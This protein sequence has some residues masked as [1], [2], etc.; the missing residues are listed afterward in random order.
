MALEAATLPIDAVVYQ[1]DLEG[2]AIVLARRP[3]TLFDVWLPEGD[4]EELEIPEPP[5]L[6]L[7]GWADRGS[8][9]VHAGDELE[10]SVEWSGD[11]VRLT[12]AQVQ[13]LAA[14]ES[15]WEHAPHEDPLVVER[16][17]QLA[18]IDRLG[19]SLLGF[20]VDRAQLRTQLAE[21]KGALEAAP[22]EFA[23]SLGDAL[24]LEEWSETLPEMLLRVRRVVLEHEERGRQLEALRLGGR[25]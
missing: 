21:A 24:G 3:G 1:A 2:S 14:G 7:W 20:E 5:A 8:R 23:R 4:L 16:A 22:G 13:A 25:P 18:R 10:V 11:W 17:D 19:Q 9:T 6:G 15:P 12:S